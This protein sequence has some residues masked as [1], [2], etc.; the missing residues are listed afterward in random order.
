[1]SWVR[2]ICFK[3]EHWNILCLEPGNIL[4]VADLRAMTEVTTTCGKSVLVAKRDGARKLLMMRMVVLRRIWAT[5][6]HWHVDDP[7]L[8]SDATTEGGVNMKK[9]KH[10]HDDAEGNWISA[11]PADG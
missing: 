10:W 4:V 3:V 5:R 1:M 11:K 8:E 2:S 9:K 6:L 7:A